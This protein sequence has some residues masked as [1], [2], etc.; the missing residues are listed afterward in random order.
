[1]L[2]VTYAS[3][4]NAL[5][6]AWFDGTTWYGNQQISTSNGDPQSQCGPW[7]APL[8]E[9]LFMLYNGDT[10][11]NVYLSVLQ[12]PEGSTPEAPIW[13]GNQLLKNFTPI[14]PETNYPGSVVPYGDGLYMAYKG[15]HGNDL[16]EAQLLQVGTSG[17]S[18]K[19][20]AAVAGR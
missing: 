14:A 15:A 7:M 4:N 19:K 18:A 17:A 2:Y 5:Y 9:A 11:N 1:M 20:A 3:Y 12:A 8:G 6:Y 16:L 10:W 13:T